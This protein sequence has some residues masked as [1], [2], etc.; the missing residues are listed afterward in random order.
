M[1]NRATADVNRA[2]GFSTSF[3]SIFVQSL[4]HIFHVTSQ[5]ATK[6]QIT[7]D[8]VGLVFDEFQMEIITSPICLHLDFGLDVTITKNTVI[9]ELC[10][11]AVHYTAMTSYV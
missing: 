10:G 2:V 7:A 4:L 9:F 8:T 3:L 11:Y 6:D 5:H 1:S